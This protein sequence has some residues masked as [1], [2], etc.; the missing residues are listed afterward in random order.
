MN[1]P[2]GKR[3]ITAESV[4]S[5]HPDKMCDIIADAILDSYLAKDPD[6]RVSC[7]V[8]AA[9]DLIFVTGEITSDTTV[10]V[11]RVVKETVE[12][13]GYSRDF[14]FDPNTLTVIVAF[15][16]QSA[17]IASGVDL[18]RDYSETTPSLGAGDQGF[19]VGFACNETNA[20]MPIPIHL[21]HQLAF[22]LEE[23]RR[24]H[25][26]PYLGPDGKTQV[27]VQYENGRAVR[28]DTVVVS[29]QHVAKGPLELLKAMIW[30][31]VVLHSIPSDLLDDRTRYLFNPTGRFVLGGPAADKGVKGR[32]IIIDAY[33][34]AARH[35]G[36]AF[37]GKDPTKV[38]RS[39][40][41]AARYVAKNIVAAG[42]ASQCEVQIAYA[43]GIAEPVSINVDTSGTGVL[44]DEVIKQVVLETFDLRPQ[45][46]IDML[47]LNRPIYE[48]TAAFGHFGRQDVD[49]P[50]EQI[51][52]Q[53]DLLQAAQSRVG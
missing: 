45:G 50:W 1:E 14:C 47:N 11:V 37:S 42:L 44:S 8:V 28:I 12:R 43:I 22:R 39:A 20:F 51:D 49:L 9:R 27:T 52:R 25:V 40:A 32:K 15:D 35:G 13:I 19:V 24:T 34:P 36:G 18:A 53:S 38:D 48:K 33:G 26:V 30:Q 31:E 21:A 4:T 29:A 6:A 23:V 46:I 5:G 41:Y 10:D 17:D 2:G 7:E 3:L 16:Q